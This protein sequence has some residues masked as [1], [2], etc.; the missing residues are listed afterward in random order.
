MTVLV[1]SSEFTKICH[2]ICRLN[3]SVLSHFAWRKIH[4]QNLRPYDHRSD[5]ALK[6]H[7]L[8]CG[9]P[10]NMLP[11]LPMDGHT[12]ASPACHSPIGKLPHR[13]SGRT[14]LASLRN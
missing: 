11:L 13:F 10:A 7:D 4:H 9:I 5:M 3:S 2:F 12:D 8:A 1:F 6:S 14:I